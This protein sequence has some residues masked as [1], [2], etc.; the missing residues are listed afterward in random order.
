MQR[1]RNRK[2]GRF[3]T[4]PAL[5]AELVR[6]VLQPPGDRLRIL[7]PACGGGV[8]LVEAC[9]F[10][11]GRGWSARE[12]AER[13]LVGVDVDPEGLAS[14]ARAVREFAGVEPDLRLGDALRRDWG[15]ERFDTVLGNPPWLSWSGRHAQSLD[16]E[17][18]RAYEA[19]YETFRGWPCMH[20]LFAELAV[21]LAHRRVGLI[22]PAQVLD[23][24]RYGP[25]RALL[26][27]E[28]RIE[29]CEDLGEAQFEGVVQSACRLIFER[30]AGGSAGGE[31]PLGASGGGSF[32]RP[33]PEWFGDIG[34]HTGNCGG[35]LLAPGG[36][37]IREGRQVHPFRIDPPVKTLRDDLPR[38]DGE[39]WRIGPLERHRRVPIL[40]RQTASRPIAALH[41]EPTYFRNSVIACWGVP[42]VAHEL[43]VA[44]LNSSAVARYHASRVRE[45][46]QRVFPQVKLRH[47]RDL[48]MPR[49]EEM[50]PELT[51]LAIAACH[52]PN[53]ADLPRLDR[54]IRSSCG[55]VSA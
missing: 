50:G 55:T 38:S 2:L 17:V 45:A 48:P 34:V 54:L 40:L 37:P 8:F 46:G 5:A 44:W 23:L 12:A 19:N 27:R 11:A 49:W 26:R 31:D 51:E 47:L 4:P 15:S 7:D 21:R 10:L 3:Y 42:G 24:E 16:P 41:R 43:V 33:R 28:G 29:E 22:L 52:D 20:S 39:Y 9:R 18:R 36:V 13:C 14:A 1:A 25:L 6:R 53:Q 30:V 35:K 32:V